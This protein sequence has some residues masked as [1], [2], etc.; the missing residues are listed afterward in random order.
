MNWNILAD[1]YC[2]EQQYPYAESWVLGW[3]YRK[4]LIVQEIASMATDIITLQEVE[5]GRSNMFG[6]GRRSTI[7][8][9]CCKK[10]STSIG[11]SP[12]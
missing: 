4:Q 3:D 8:W 5:E 2:T 10:M 9:G 11:W 1:Q 12:R 7:A 6:S